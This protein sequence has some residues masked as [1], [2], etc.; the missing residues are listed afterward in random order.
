MPPD[1][2]D[3][4]GNISDG[5]TQT[6]VTIPDHPQTFQERLTQ[7]QEQSQVW[8]YI[9]DKLEY[10]NFTCKTEREQVALL[11][12]LQL[13]K[14]NDLDDDPMR[15]M[16]KHQRRY[17][18]IIGSILQVVG[19]KGYCDACRHHARKN[20]EHRRKTCIGLPPTATGP[21]YKDLVSFVAGRCSNC[22]RSTYL[23]SSCHF[24]AGE[25]PADVEGE[26]ILGATANHH[27]DP[28]HA[29]DE[30][31]SYVDSDSTRGN[32]ASQN[33]ER[34]QGTRQ[35]TQGH[36]SRARANGTKK[37]VRPPSAA[38]KPLEAHKPRASEEGASNNAEFVIR[39]AII[40][41]F[42]ASTQLRPEEQQG[43]HE[44]VTALFSFS[45]SSPDLG[46]Q[47]L[48]ALARLRQLPAGAQADIRGRVLQMLP[49]A[50]GRPA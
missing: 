29:G 2:D 28:G 48:A 6:V 16:D 10:A 30:G 42:R 15:A 4:G 40:V 5:K 17:N 46:G 43:F 12:I 24:A 50:M 3:E 8:H 34:A 1:C 35:P 33:R 7:A 27:R 26:E 44:W 14:Q 37:K 9:K 31:V 13:P 21:K 22:I 36:R 49:G 39:D 47:A 18:V 38:P 25:A 41:G 19:V 32:V 23:S 11:E 20:S 45:S